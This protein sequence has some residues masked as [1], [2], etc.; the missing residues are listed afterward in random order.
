M[1]DSDKTEES[2]LPTVARPN[3]RARLVSA[4]TD[5]F[6]RQGVEKTTLAD[7]AEA[8]EVPLGNIYYYFRTKDAIVDAVVEAHVQG[9]EETLATLD[10][11][12]RTPKGRLKG[13]FGTLEDR[14]DVIAEFGCPHGT[15]CSELEKRT[16][17]DDHAVTR[18][19]EIPLAW[20]EKQF[21]AMGRDDARDLALEFI[22]SYQ[23]ATVLTQ[24]LRQPSL[25]SKE[26]RRLQRWIDS[27]ETAD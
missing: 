18:L 1:T 27:L 20:A 26:S 16:G 14:Y 23:G 21:R 22:A 9:L 24:A 13:L 11:R 19:L 7:I 15:L 8:A 4:A 6:Y 12:Y 17:H 25:L 10:R 5:L 3:K 2:A